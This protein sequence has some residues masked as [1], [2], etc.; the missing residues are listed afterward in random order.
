MTDLKNKLDIIKKAIDSKN[1]L[2][3]VEIDVSQKTSIA[4]YFI[5][6][7]GNSS[8]QA[9]AIADEVEDKMSKA[10]YEILNIKEGYRSARWIILDFADVIVH[11]F[12]KEERDYY[13]LERLWKEFEKLSK[14]EE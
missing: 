13:D 4:D 3:T 9:V 8:N 1:G 10:G 7:S 5:I 14:E 12:H 6:T 11:V 2:D